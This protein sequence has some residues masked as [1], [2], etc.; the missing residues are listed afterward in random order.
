MLKSAAFIT[1]IKTKSI[2][3]NSS[4]EREILHELSICC[5]S[6]FPKQT[7]EIAIECWSWIISSR[8]DI[9]PL[10]VEEMINAWQMTV[11]LR[12]VMFSSK[13]D[14]PNPLAKEEKDE[15]KPRPPANIDAHRVWI[16]YFQERLDIAKNKSDFENELFFN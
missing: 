7:I 10:V 4:Y 8:P 13:M 2:E 12:L 1:L 3:I 15:L 5:S 9:E 16:K 6:L 14:E 11:E